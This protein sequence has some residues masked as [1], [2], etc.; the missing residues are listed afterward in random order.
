M[1]K[2]IFEG[3]ARQLAQWRLSGG[4]RSDDVYEAEALAFRRQFGPE[5][6][7][8]L[9][10]ADLLRLMHERREGQARCMAYW[11]EFKKD[12]EFVTDHFGGIGGGSALKFGLYQREMDSAWVT[13]NPRQMEVVP[14]A[15]AIILARQ[16]RDELLQ[17]CERLAAFDPS[18]ASDESFVRLQ[19]LMEQAAPDLARSGWAHKY[20]YLVHPEAV[21]GFHSPQYQRFTLLKLLQTPPDRIGIRDSKA[22]RFNCAA[23]FL[24]IARG[25]G[26]SMY[27]FGQLINVS[28]GRSHRYWKV[29]T[30]EGTGG[31]SVWPSMRDKSVVSIGWS[32]V[33]ADMTSLLDMGDQE[34]RAAIRSALRPTYSDEGV[35]T[36]KTGEVFNFLREMKPSDIVL[37]CEGSQVLGIGRVL[38]SYSYA[39]GET[40][41]HQRRV[42]WLNVESWS[43]R[44]VEGPR[45]T[46][47][48][49]GRSVDNILE[50]ERRLQAPALSTSAHPRPVAPPTE[51]RA[52]PLAPLDSR[53][54][55]LDAVLRR[56]G[57][58]ILYGPPGTGKTFHAL[59]ATRELAARHAFGQTLAALDEP[60]RAAL[61]G[62]EGLVELCSFHPGW[63]Y[64]DFVEGLRPRVVDRQMTFEPRDG[65]FKTMCKRAAKRPD[66]RYFLV[67]DEFNRGDLP[68][69][70]GELMTALE[71]D[72]RK[73]GVLLPLRGERLVVPPNLAIVGTMNTADRSIS[74]LDAAL[75]RR[76]GFIELMPDSRALGEQRVEDLHLGPWLD[77]LNARLR[78]HLKRDARNL[79]VG[80]AYLM[81]TP[82][83]DS[84]EAFARVLRDDIIPLLEDYCYEDFE[85]LAAILGKELVDVE[86]ACI[87]ESW[88][89]ADSG[90]NLLS[91]VRF[92]EMEQ[93]GLAMNPLEAETRSEAGDEQEADT[94]SAS[95]DGEI[96][97][98]T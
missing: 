6:L 86:S 73:E 96:P 39:P 56:K 93:Y 30:T 28:Q 54:Q 1:D 26:L 50:I 23:R 13:G 66:R 52:V 59:Q 68:R 45:T 10:G 98:R 79:Q 78:K 37:A 19:M 22:A 87:D 90:R 88:F 47:F 48:E 43:L 34:A 82:P 4:V 16:Q 2:A 17:G 5:V 76:F 89:A 97:S 58:A 74:L 36:R 80:H 32:E 7:A 53:T 81:S 29:G 60:E 11:L 12:D 38:E 65:I 84:V 25:L 51:A 41:P 42:E 3:L 75:R 71:P 70:F 33:L 91:A 9:D 95:A 15:K 92:E 18:G 55:R 94:E 27:T 57:Q 49:L 72:K 31:E 85:T 67:I 46:V 69:I 62:D 14:E 63:G 77:A 35:T 24:Q 40:F 21:D 20:W 8:T 44:E 64:E 83:I 61:S